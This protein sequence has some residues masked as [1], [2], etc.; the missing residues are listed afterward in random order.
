M[1][2]IYPV[3]ENT[4][5]KDFV[6]LFMDKNS[7]YKKYLFGTNNLAETLS[8][9]VTVDG[10]INTYTS[11]KK[12]LG[13]PILH[14][15]DELPENALVLS[16]VF[17]GSIIIIMRKLSFYRFRSLDC[18]SFLK[19]SK[20]PIEL[21]HFFGWK[22][23]I[24]KNYDKF[25]NIFNLLADEKSKNIFHNLVNFK[26]S[27]DTKYLEGFD[28]PSDEQYFDDC[29]QLPEKP[30]FA[31]IGGY[32]GFTTLKFIEHYPCYKKV[33]FFEP[34]ENNLRN[35]KKNLSK[36]HD[37]IFIQKGLADQETTLHFSINDSASKICEE[38]E[39]S[40]D[41]AKLDNLVDEEI[42]FMKMDIEGAEGGAISGARETI[43][44]H[45]PT[46]A[47]CVYHRPDDFWKIPEQVFSIRNDY[48][49]F[50]RHYTQGSDETV[51]FFIP[52]R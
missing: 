36:F 17:L 1:L 14:N 27:G 47:I 28:P 51:M 5:A 2:Q 13:K 46:M 10:Y 38:G 21:Y 44:K 7:S 6:R 32:D 20:I 3:Y 31:D 19:A 35:A 22:E 43:K 34:E 26:I 41:V 33:F 9:Y 48:K 50:M 12:F 11:E 45:H 49:L 40:I 15:L 37:I 30:V 8:Q 4:Y 24:N 29:L 23:E 42:H 18:Y 52:K 25:N 39:N 16:C